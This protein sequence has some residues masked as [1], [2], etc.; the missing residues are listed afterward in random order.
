MRAA[1]KRKREPHSEGGEQRREGRPDIPA[2][3]S[4]HAEEGGVRG[5]G[6]LSGEETRV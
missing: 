5:I 2:Q 6:P 4:R 3:E 1:G